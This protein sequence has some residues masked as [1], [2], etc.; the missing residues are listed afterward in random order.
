MAVV[1]AAAVEAMSV[2]AATV[3]VVA[4]TTVTVTVT[5]FCAIARW[6]QNMNPTIVR[7]EYFMVMVIRIDVGAVVVVVVLNLEKEV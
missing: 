7:R 1:A 2:V 3:S 4:C 5:V 6:A